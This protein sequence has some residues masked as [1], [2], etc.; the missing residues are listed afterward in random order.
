MT[1]RGGAR[2]SWVS[3]IAPGRE[4]LLPIATL[5][6]TPYREFSETA[7]VRMCRLI[8]LEHAGNW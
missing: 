1:R 8:G 6:S 5:S 7:K 2:H 4:W 3:N